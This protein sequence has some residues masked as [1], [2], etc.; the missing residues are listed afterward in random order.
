MSDGVLG[1][2]LIIALF[3]VFFAVATPLVY[4]LNVHVIGPSYDRKAADL[5]T[6]VAAP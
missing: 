4:A 3:V 5:F 1:P 6:R 2:L